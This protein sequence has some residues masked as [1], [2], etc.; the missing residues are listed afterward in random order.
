MGLH[1]LVSCRGAVRISSPVAVKIGKLEWNK[2]CDGRDT[3]VDLQAYLFIVQV[4]YICRYNDEDG[5]Y[6][7]NTKS[8][9][10]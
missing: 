1:T 9:V 7:K 8:K 5:S 3:L 2:L 6:R 4:S 10:A